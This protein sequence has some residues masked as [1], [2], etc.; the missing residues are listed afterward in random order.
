MVDIVP[1]VIRALGSVTTE[2][3]GWTEKL[4]I[5]NNVGV[6]QK[7]ALLGTARILRKALEILRRYH[8]ARLWSFVMTRLT[9]EMTTVT[10]A[11]PDVKEMIAFLN[12]H[13]L[14]IFM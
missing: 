13:G 12:V 3:E 8:S 6:M 4:G 10:T 14:C 1:V 7:T 11:K 5:T 9:E 2:F